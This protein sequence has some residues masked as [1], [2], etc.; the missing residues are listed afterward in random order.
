MDNY[1]KMLEFGLCE[2]SFRLG[3]CF[4]SFLQHLAGTFSPV[5]PIPASK[6]GCESLAATFPYAAR[7]PGGLRRSF[8][9][10][11]SSSASGPVGSRRREYA[12]TGHIQDPRLS[13]RCWRNTMSALQ[14]G[15][16]LLS[17]RF[18][19]LSPFSLTQPHAPVPG[20]QMMHPEIKKPTPGRHAALWCWFNDAH[21]RAAY[22][23]GYELRSCKC[24][25]S[26]KKFIPNLQ[27]PAPRVKQNRTNR[28]E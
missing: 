5:S 27:N 7:R 4:S 11:P 8:G 1:L 16:T 12:Q 13:P 9:S 2:V 24:D 23:G 3:H 25:D 15:Q 18:M 10:I 26:L 19:T 21:E 6:P 28:I 17:M 22:Y 20:S 14:T